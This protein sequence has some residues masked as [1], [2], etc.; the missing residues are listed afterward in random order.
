[1]ISLC[2][3]CLLLCFFVLRWASSRRSP[4]RQEKGRDHERKKK[5]LERGRE[6]HE[7]SAV[8][9]R[10]GQREDNHRR[11]QETE[12]DEETQFIPSRNEVHPSRLTDIDMELLE[13]TRPTRTDRFASERYEKVSISVFTDSAKPKDLRATESGRR[14]RMERGGE[15]EG[16]RRGR[17]RG[18]EGERG[19]RGS[20]RVVEE[21]GGRRGRE[22]EGEGE[23]GGGGGRRGRERV[24]EGEGEGGGRRGRERVGEG[25]ETGVGEGGRRGR[26]RGRGFEG[27]GGMEDRLQERERQAKRLLDSLTDPRD[28]PKST[29]YFEVR[30]ES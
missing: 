14:V 16:G 28:V 23:G 12:R 21:E 19:R 5:E 13:D 7:T 27:R 24:G 6:S 10:V 18:G 22:G 20:E 4:E 30:K 2:T 11:R 1:M 9:N 17:E 25:E 3:K 29:W 15:G 26:G 8:G